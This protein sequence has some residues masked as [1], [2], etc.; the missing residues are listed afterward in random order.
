MNE[1]KQFLTEQWNKSIIGLS[2]DE[3]VEK[4]EKLQEEA[5]MYYLDNFNKVISPLNEND[6]TFVITA[7]TI[8][9]QTILKDCDDSELMVAA[10]YIKNHKVDVERKN[11]G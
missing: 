3:I 4:F 2:R 11:N 10:D 6:R 7:L 8:W 1:K 9:L 5:V